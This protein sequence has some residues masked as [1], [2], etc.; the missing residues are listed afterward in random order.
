MINR[1]QIR[2]KVLQALYALH[3]SGDSQGDVYKRLLSDTYRALKSFKAP[4]KPAQEE[5][6]QE[7][8]QYLSSLYMDLLK[9]EGEY[10]ELLKANLQNWEWERVALLDRLM[11]QMGLHELLACPEVPV[12]VTLNEYLEI[13][14]EYSTDKSS[15]F[16]NG[17]LDAV[18]EKLQAEGRI[19]K[20][21][22]GLLTGTNK[23]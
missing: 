4:D 11:L 1:R 13:A 9:H 12:K 2:I 14:K 17:I 5:G 16:I 6:A 3:T 7:D 19:K 20:E 23:P 21:G 22:R 18:R 10:T 8:A 15:Q